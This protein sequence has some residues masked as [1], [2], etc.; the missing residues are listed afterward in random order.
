MWS[1]SY[2]LVLNLYSLSEK[3]PSIRLLR[4]LNRLSVHQLA[5]GAISHKEAQEHKARNFCFFLTYSYGSLK[6]IDCL[7]NLPNDLSYIR[8]EESKDI[9][10]KLDEVLAG[11]YL[12]M[13]N[14]EKDTN[15]SHFQ[16]LKKEIKTSS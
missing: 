15:F 5:L 8:T 9:T 6:E 3:Y 7:L 12:L 2:S 10:T 1:K 13:R 4:C 16:K 14:V 11:L